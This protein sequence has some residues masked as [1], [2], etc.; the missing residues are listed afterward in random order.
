MMS[1]AASIKGHEFVSY[2]RIISALFNPSKMQLQNILYLTALLAASS[3]L[4]APA[5]AP[6]GGNYGPAGVSDSRSTR[7][8]D[9]SHELI[10]HI[11]TKVEQHAEVPR[12][13]AEAETGVRHWVGTRREVDSGIGG[14][15][16]RYQDC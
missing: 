3:S 11:T 4:A 9:A 2:L 14:C 12:T 15:H 6:E 5:P 16:P 7:Q 8:G 13:Q 1:Q 10:D